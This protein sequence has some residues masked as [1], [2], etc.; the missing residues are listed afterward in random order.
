MPSQPACLDLK[1]QIVAYKN[2][3]AMVEVNYIVYICV[4]VYIDIQVDKTWVH[5]TCLNHYW[6]VHATYKAGMRVLV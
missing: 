6:C 3:M 5:L 1:W 2:I 4:I